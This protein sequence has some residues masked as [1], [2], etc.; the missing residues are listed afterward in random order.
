ML[1][2]IRDRLSQNNTLLNK[3]VALKGTGAGLDSAQ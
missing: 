2:G 3:L 1:L